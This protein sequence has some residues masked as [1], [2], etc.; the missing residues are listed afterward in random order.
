MIL[1]SSVEL[2]YSWNQICLFDVFY[3]INIAIVMLMNVKPNVFFLFVFLALQ[4]KQVSHKTFFCD[5]YQVQGKL[6]ACF[7][8]KSL[9][10]IIC[11]LID[12]AVCHE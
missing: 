11:S 5:T 7:S 4:Q 8:K 9:N 6:Y 2:L 3:S 1:F 12:W 10:V